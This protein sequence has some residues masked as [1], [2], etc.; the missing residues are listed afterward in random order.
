MPN[1][2]IL[3]KEFKLVFAQINNRGKLY[4]GIAEAIFASLI[5][6]FI[7]YIYGNLVDV[8]LKPGAKLEIIFGW[9]ILWVALSFISNLLVRQTDRYGYE[10]A[11]DITN[12]LFVDLFFHLSNLPLSFH[13]ER[14]T[15]KVTRRAQRGID[16][17][18]DL[19]ERTVFDFLP[20]MLSFVVALVILFFVEWRLSLI[21][22]FFS[23]LYILITFFQTKKIIKK[24][25]T[26]YQNWEKA[27]GEL[28]DSVINVQTVKSST[29]EEFEEKRNAKNFNL[30][31]RIFKNWRFLWTRMSFW[32]QTIFA[33]AFIAVFVTG[34]LML[35]AGRLTP[36]LL[37]MFV[38][39]TSLLT[40]PLARL[41]DQYRQAKTAVEA[42]ARAAKYYEILPE[43]DLAGSKEIN[44][45]GQVVFDKV[46]FV[47]KKGGQEVLKNISFVVQPGQTLALVGG[48]GVGKSTLAD[49]IGRY[50]LT[51]KG[52]LFIDGVNIKKIKL[53]SLREQMAV[54][55]QEVLL[56]NDTIENNIKYGYPKATKKQIIE[57]CQAANAHD[58]IESF[59]KKYKQ[60]VGERGI[61]LSVGQKQRVAIARAILRNPKILIL[62]E[63]TSALDSVSEKLV[64]EALQKLIQGRTTFV[65]AHRLSTIQHADKIIVLEKG[66]VAEMGTHE[67]LMQNPDGIYRNFW[68][69]QTAIKKVK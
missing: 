14:K 24:Q 4:L 47:Y 36:G 10:L 67:E 43:K 8:A 32:Q 23:L 28:Y 12:K 5:V 50:Y 66:G 35:Q 6:A 63:A 59:S 15:G 65:I 56:F 2:M 19:I 37:I 9:V 61:K 16:E 41:A 52:N 49:L 13:K 42:F 33:S 64:Q 68:E 45:K 11:T 26:M 7:P 1:I 51:Q 58:F 3:S 54:V 55:P 60:V 29:A 21:L 22:L 40:S 25:K 30:A 48:S 39:Y 38:G 53:R 27:Y 34:V 44:I 17:L 57:A 62:D 69:L 20:S 46:S 18:F 31:G